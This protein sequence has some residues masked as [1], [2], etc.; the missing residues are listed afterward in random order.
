MQYRHSRLLQSKCASVQ[1]SFSFPPKISSEGNATRNTTKGT[2]TPRIMGATRVLFGEG[3]PRFDYKFMFKPF[4][5]I[6]TDLPL[7]SGWN[8]SF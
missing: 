3:A 5:N 2:Y 4:K 1:Y 6:F 7:Y 8:K